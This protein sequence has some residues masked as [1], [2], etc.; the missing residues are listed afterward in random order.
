MAREFGYSEDWRPAPP[1]PPEG[2]QR[3]KLESL[4]PFRWQPPPAPEWT[5]KDAAGKEHSLKDYKG[6]PV[7]VIFY[8]GAACLHCAKQLAEFAP[9]AEEF[10]KAGIE[11][12]AISTDA[13]EQLQLKLANFADTEYPFPLVSNNRLDVFKAYG[14]FD[15][16]ERQPLHGTFLIDADGLVR[17]KDISYE[18]FMEPKFVLAEARR[19]LS[20]G[21]VDPATSAATAG[22]K[23]E[24][25]PEDKTARDSDSASNQDPEDGSPDGN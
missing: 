6:K 2:S 3:P 23:N 16:F 17:W 18:P 4:G 15:D 13:P 10:Q 20:T 8:L 22:S 1:A 11:M 14:C 19:L 7:V 25:D 5:L 24:T 9:K 12:I 21:P